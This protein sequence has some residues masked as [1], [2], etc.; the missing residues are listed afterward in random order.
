[1]A[2]RSRI[3]YPSNISADPT[4]QGYLSEIA[5]ILNQLPNISIQSE[6]G[7]LESAVSGNYGDLAV[8]V[9]GGAGEL[10]LKASGEEN[11][12]G[13]SNV[14]GWP[15]SYAI[16]HVPTRYGQ[17]I[18]DTSGENELLWSSGEI[19]ATLEG[20]DISW[21]KEGVSYKGFTVDTSGTYMLEIS[22]C[23]TGTAGTTYHLT[24]RTNSSSN[25]AC[26]AYAYTPATTEII[27][28]GTGPRILNLS[29]GDDISLNVT[30][31]QGSDQGMTIRYLNLSIMKI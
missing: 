29:N 31:D 12:A 30:H 7:G 27:H 1:M 23:L 18:I 8:N 11:T 26:A 16:I 22:S 14:G 2:R 4:V 6:S 20:T 24:Y 13:W 5:D 21:L 28:T 19:Q 25:I 10:W 9:A 3:A 15:T 17:E